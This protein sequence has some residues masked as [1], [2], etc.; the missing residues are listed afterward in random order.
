VA[1]VVTV[2]EAALVVAVA[3]AGGFESATVGTFE[4]ETLTGGFESDTLAGTF[5]S[6]TLPG[7][8]ESVVL[9]GVLA[10][11][12]TTRQTFFLLTTLHT[13]FVA[14]FFVAAE[15]GAMTAR[16]SASVAAT[17]EHETMSRWDREVMPISIGGFL[18]EASKRYLWSAQVLRS[19][20]A[21][22]QVRFDCQARL[23]R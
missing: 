1:L 20:I 3:A 8:V 5:E 22:P 16:V 13:F 14:I 15:V 4:S 6:E 7:T 12:F 10:A 18:G 19:A 2:P 21:N 23:G 17:A 11:T 9:D